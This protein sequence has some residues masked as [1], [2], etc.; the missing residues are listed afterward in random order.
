MLNSLRTRAAFTRSG[1]DIRRQELID[2]CARML[3]ERGADGVSVRTICAAAGVSPGLLRHYFA[4]ID[5]LIAAT[6]AH[7][8]ERVK[9]AL[10]EAVADAAG[11]RRGQ[12]N[13]YVTASFR[14]PITEP[15]ML[16]TWLAF[17]SL[18]KTDNEVARLH[19][20]IYASYRNGLEDL[21]AECGVGPAELRLVAVAV[22]A[23]I[24]GLWL[25]LCL[26][27]STLSTEEASRIAHRWLDALLRQPRF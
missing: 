24:D 20:D 13:A 15:A 3:A 22:T 6:Y 9:R 2:A 27:P 11:T 4:G 12:L 10:D 26:D 19:G 1:P 7:V 16:S 18:V 8:G 17:W 14:P 21:L 25:E 5:D 23:L